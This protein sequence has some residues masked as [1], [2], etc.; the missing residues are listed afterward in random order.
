MV[1]VTRMPVGSFGHVPAPA[2][3]APLESILE[4]SHYRALGGHEDKV[5][6]AA[7]V[8]ERG[9]EYGRALRVVDR[10]RPKDRS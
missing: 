2:L 9:V 4:R 6:G 8:L 5:R 1:D 7:N 10:P 3:V